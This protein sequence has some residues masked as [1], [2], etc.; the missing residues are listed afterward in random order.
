MVNGKTV[1]GA[2]DEIDSLGTFVELELAADE[3]SLPEA[4]AVIAAL[5]GELK[6]GPS[7]RRSYLELLL[8]E[9]RQLRTPR[10]RRSL[11]RNGTWFAV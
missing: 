2:W 6:L 10:N 1:H 3:K 5:A 8:A 7:E 9:A 4:K 11:H